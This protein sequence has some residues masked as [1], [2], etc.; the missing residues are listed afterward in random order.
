MSK[1]LKTRPLHV[2][3]LD[4]KD[5]AVGIAEHHN[6]EKGFCDLPERTAKAIEERH[7]EMVKGEYPYKTKETCRYDFAYTGVGICGCTFCTG[8]EGR[9]MKARK[10]RHVAKDVLSKETREIQAAMRASG[11]LE[12]EELE[13][14][15]TPYIM[16][17]EAY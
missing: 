3:I 15:E 7:E 14:F 10:T 5:H 4:P 16:S 6:H 17:K 13:D 2:R 12:E 11:S 8:Q 1:T 9:K